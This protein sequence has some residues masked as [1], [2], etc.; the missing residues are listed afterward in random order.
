VIRLPGGAT[1]RLRPD[2]GRCRTCRA[3]L[4]PA[5]CA[6]RRADGIEVIG[7]AACAAAAG[8]GHRPVAAALA[9]PAGTVR[10]CLRTQAEQLRW[11]AM[12][13]LAAIGGYAPVSPL[14]KALNA[15]AA[16]VARRPARSHNRRALA[17]DRPVRPGP[18]PCVGA[19]RL[20]TAAGPGHRHTLGQ[21]ATFPVPMM[22]SQWPRTPT[23]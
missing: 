23:P 17:A 14:G 5:W 20:I 16:A 21:A 1:A 10:G 15:V 3:I 19:Q 13:E 18:L 11:F 6:P 4:L 7:T 9:V 8:Q 12:G 22:A 2:R